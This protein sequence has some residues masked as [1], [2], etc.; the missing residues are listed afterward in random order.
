MSRPFRLTSSACRALQDI[1][2]YTRERWS[3]AQAEKYLGSLHQKFQQL[4]E[5]PGIGRATYPGSSVRKVVHQRHTIY[6]RETPQ[7]LEVGRIV[8]PGQ[9]FTKELERYERYARRQAQGQ[10]QKLKS[11]RRR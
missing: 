3:T 5:M 10:S 7:G 4:V 11:K 9:D 6:Y 2:R 8:G 1:Y